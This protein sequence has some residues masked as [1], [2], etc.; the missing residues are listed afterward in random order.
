V[1]IKETHDV[2]CGAGEPSMPSA[3]RETA[4]EDALVE[5]VGLHADAIPE[6]RPTGERARRIDRNHADRSARLSQMED[7]PIHEG[8]RAGSRWTGD[9]DD[10][11]VPRA[12]VD[13]AHDAAG[14]WPAVLDDGDE[15][16][17]RDTVAA[18]HALGQGIDR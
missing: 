12:L 8:R 2:T 18:E 14:L 3:R 16:C 15:S 7:Q 5:K 1:G 4:Y 6:H 9:A 13:R 11:R 17:E 10:V